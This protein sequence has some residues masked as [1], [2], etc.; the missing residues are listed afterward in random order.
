MS[1]LFSLEGKTAVIMGGNS[2]LARAIIE[3]F[4]LHG[5]KIAS[6]VM[7]PEYAPEV[8]E[9]V[10]ALGGEI[11]SFVA[12]VTDLESVQRAADEIEAWAGSV[13]ILL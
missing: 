9:Q 1:D 2:T 6:V 5:A 11:K 4:V 3:G 10:R 13:D 7:K 12:D 8:E